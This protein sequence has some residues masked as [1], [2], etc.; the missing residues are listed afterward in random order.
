MRVWLTLC[1][2]HLQLHNTGLGLCA[3]CQ[4]AGDILGC[5]MALAPCSDSQQQQVGTPS[6]QESREDLKVSFLGCTSTS[7]W[8]ISFQVAHV[9]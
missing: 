7:L 3:D 9:P 2:V 1:D 5:A 4:A 6:S 8:S